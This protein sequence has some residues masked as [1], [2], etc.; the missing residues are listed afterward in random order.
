MANCILYKETSVKVENGSIMPKIKS[1]P[2]EEDKEEEFIIIPESSGIS[3]N[4]GTGNHGG[5]QAASIETKSEN[6][7]PIA[8]GCSAVDL[9]KKS[10]EL[11]VKRKSPERPN[12]NILETVENS[13]QEVEGSK[14]EMINMLDLLADVAMRISGVSPTGI[15]NNSEGD[16]QDLPKT[17]QLK[18]KASKPDEKMEVKVECLQKESTK[19]VSFHPSTSQV[20]PFPLWDVIG[21]APEHADLVTWVPPKKI[22][23]IKIAV[24]F[25]CLHI[26]IFIYSMS[27]S[28]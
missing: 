28:Q 13:R 22:P 9:E 1:E 3:A 10:T 14:T 6:L 12:V 7:Q 15:P 8:K 17:I 11:D 21:K 2:M 4:F 5:P 24:L 26:I 25:Y 18:E 23:N 19:A 20:A 27:F 16:S